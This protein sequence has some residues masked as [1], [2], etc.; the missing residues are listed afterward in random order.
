MNLDPLGLLASGALL[1]AAEPAEAEKII[2]ALARQKIPC[3]EI[4][5][6]TEQAEGMTVMIGGKIF[7]L[8]PFER[9][10]ITRVL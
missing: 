6:F 2:G 4:G 8:T 5:K 3:A 7:P 10:E 9:D 1:I